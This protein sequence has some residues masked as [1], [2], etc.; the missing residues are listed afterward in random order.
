MPTPVEV[1]EAAAL[2]GR[3]AMAWY[4][5]RDAQVAQRFSD[6]IEA[7]MAKIAAAPLRGPRH[8]AGTR[9]CAIDRFPYWM[10]YR[11]DEERVV[12][13][14]IAHTSRTPTYWVDR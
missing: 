4:E 2:D 7:T 5:E 6:A 12:V 13:V 1:V 8:L 11:G 10:V 9:R 3:D 14:A